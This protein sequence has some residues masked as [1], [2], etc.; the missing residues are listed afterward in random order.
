MRLAIVILGL[1]AIAVALVQF[2]KDEVVARHQMRQLEARL[3][4]Q[5][6]QLWSQEAALAQLESPQ[7]LRLRAQEMD[8]S[9][10]PAQQTPSAPLAWQE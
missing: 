10:E 5:R 9:L 4:E 2:R 7:S 8:L 3:I 6:Q 1:A